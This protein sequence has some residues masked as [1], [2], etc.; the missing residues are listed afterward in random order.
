MRAIEK[1]GKPGDARRSQFGRVGPARA[2]NALLAFSAAK[3]RTD[4]V[5]ALLAKVIGRR[6]PARRDIR[7]RRRRDLVADSNLNLIKGKPV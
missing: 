7:G 2:S 1:A 4:P 6:N 5:H 3:L